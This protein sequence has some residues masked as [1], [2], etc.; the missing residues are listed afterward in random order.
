M[1]VRRWI[2]CARMVAVFPRRRGK[3]FRWPP[4]DSPGH[5]RLRERPVARVR[6][7]VKPGGFPFVLWRSGLCPDGRD[8]DC[9]R[10]QSPRG[11]C[12]AR[13]RRHP[14]LS[15]RPAKTVPASGH[16]RIRAARRGRGRAVA[17]ANDLRS[18]SWPGWRRGS[19]PVDN[20]LG[21]GDHG[22]GVCR[23]PAPPRPPVVLGHGLDILD[24]TGR[25]LR[26]RQRPGGG[27]QRAIRPRRRFRHIGSR[28]H[29]IGPLRRPGRA[30]GRFFSWPPSTSDYSSPP[31]VA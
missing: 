5:R 15:L 19:D 24:H 31:P 3:V 2:R 13:R 21:V 9:R 14:G 23:L 16:A 1:G 11:P 18:R 22:S 28:A 17:G 4:A 27:S 10:V 25:R 26:R 12:P 8:G 20:G 29:G 7:A 6:G 30:G